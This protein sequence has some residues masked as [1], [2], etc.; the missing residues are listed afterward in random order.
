MARSATEDQKRM[1]A[2]FAAEF[3]QCMLCGWGMDRPWRTFRKWMIPAVDNAHIIGGSGRSHDRRNI[4]RLC[5]GCH[6]LHH[7]HRIMVDG[8]YLPFVDLEHLLWIK[9]A[10]DPEFYDLQYLIERRGRVDMDER[11]RRPPDGLLSLRTRFF[12]YK[13]SVSEV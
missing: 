11:P 9:R 6:S 5:R 7:H 13:E 8:K 2:E 12:P 1:Y 10:Y 3:P 4:V